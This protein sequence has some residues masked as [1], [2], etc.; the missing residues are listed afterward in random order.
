MLHPGTNS[1]GPDL[2]ETKIMML[3]A[4]F[5]Y[6]ATLATLM[7]SSIF[8]WARGVQPS[9]PQRLVDDNTAFALELY[10]HLKTQPGNVFFSP[11]SISTCLG[12]TY[13]GAHGETADQMAKALHFAKDQQQFHASFGQLQRQLKEVQNRKGIELNIANAL[14]TQQGHPFGPTFL[15]VARG[16]YEANVNQADFKTGAEAA[17]QGI[18]HWIAETTKDKIKDILPLGSVNAMTRLVLANAV[19][20]K[21]AW[22]VPFPKTETSTQSFH[23]LGGSQVNVPLMHHFDTVHY[24]ENDKFQAVELPYGSNELSM[25]V[26]LPRQMDGCGQLENSLTP[27]LLSRSLGEMRTRRVEIFL[28]RFKLESSFMLNNELGKMGMTDA[29]GP[30]AD[31]SGIDGTRLLYISGVFHKAWGEVNEEGTEA[32]AA[33]AVAMRAMAIHKPP[34]PPP[35]FRAD[36]PF[37][38]F[39]RETASG[40][41]LFLGRLAEPR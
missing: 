37:L 7:L 36:H 26:L 35:V 38:F 39:I 41:L 20:F 16:E 6:S 18:N 3:R 40:S 29:F 25:V 15:K 10:G 23:L 12:M 17:R 5:I 13:A 8:G 2:R 31:F 28:P 4:Q 21:G 32:A 22:A 30:R 33:T 1:F 9:Q 27:A 19:Y 24:M 11:Y 34:P 14:W